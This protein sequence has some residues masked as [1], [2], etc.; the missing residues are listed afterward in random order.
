MSLK[1]WEEAG[2]AK[3]FPNPSSCLAEI[4]SLKSLDQFLALKKKEIFSPSQHEETF[5]V[6]SHIK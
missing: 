5:H 3:Q 2:V 4:L 1:A 6:L